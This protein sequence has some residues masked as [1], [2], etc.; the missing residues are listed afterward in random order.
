[1]SP[2]ATQIS[3]TSQNSLPKNREL[4]INRGRSASAAP[5]H[6]ISPT[7]RRQREFALE[8]IQN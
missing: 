8:A 2:D 6:V 7:N 5:T 3:N 4:I 1:M